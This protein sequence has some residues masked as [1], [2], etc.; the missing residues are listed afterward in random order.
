M[1][2]T[3]EQQK[4]HDQLVQLVQAHMDGVNPPDE[5][6]AAA[7]TMQ[8]VPDVQS[9]EDA[10]GMARAYARIRDRAQQAGETA[11]SQTATA[12][13]SI[14][15]PSAPPV[16]S[17]SSTKPS[18]R[19]VANGAKPVDQELTD[20]QNQA[21]QRRQTAA[22][23]NAVT[24][25][26][27]VPDYGMEA[28]MR[29]G[30]GGGGNTRAPHDDQWDKYSE[31]GDR[32]LKD[33]MTRRA[34]ESDLE[35]KQDEATK[36]AENKDANSG[37]AQVTRLL[38]YKYSPDLVGKLDD[39]TVDEMSPIAG[40][41]LGKMID[42]MSD[43]QKAEVIAKSK[44]A[45]DAAKTESEKEKELERQREFDKTNGLGNRQA[46][47]TNRHNLATEGL[48]TSKAAAKAAGHGPAPVAK[49]GDLA[50]VPEDIRAEVQRIANG[51][52]PVPV[53]TSR[54]ARLKN[55]VSQFAP[56]LDSAGFATRKAVQEQIAKSPE[57]VAINTA[58]EHLA[59]ARSH[60]PE[61]FDSQSLNR[62]KQVYLTQ[63]GSDKLSPFEMDVK[64]A[65]DELAK[66]YGNNSEAGRQTIEHLLDP[67]QS[68]EQLISRLNETLALL[69]GK[70]HAFQE[71][72]D[73][74]AK[75]G[76]FSVGSA[77]EAQAPQA[78]GKP[79]PGP[80]YVRGKT[81]SGQP[82]W[83]N[84]ETHNFEAD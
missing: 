35:K 47:E 44:A 38:I 28:A 83:Y 54:N 71:Q 82:G 2:L 27:E 31:E 55:A 66:A 41:A 58:S 75:P 36:T 84:A 8:D 19:V 45:S 43:S 63:S 81:K 48:G 17:T 9:E 10:N 59:L 16:S 24:R 73:R 53:W 52:E 13:D 37:K 12:A 18:D 1:D 21:A 77:P 72:Y 29:L 32:Q 46:D 76:K 60:V 23:G 70:R 62:I 4:A 74:A 5:A 51:D 78:A 80:G 34:S 20:L 64:V 6:E 22:L 30:K 33:L 15:T 14:G 25:F 61:N 3:P 40:P 39:K 69:E 42:G 79:S 50:S 49:E 57:L 65:A 7:G 56:H 11:S 26:T 67:N 68:K